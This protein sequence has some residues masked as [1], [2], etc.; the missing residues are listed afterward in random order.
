MDFDEWHH[1]LF[2]AT[3]PAAELAPDLWASYRMDGTIMLQWGDQ[4]KVVGLSD[5]YF[6]LKKRSSCPLEDLKHW[7]DINFPVQCDLEKRNSYLCYNPDVRSYNAYVMR[8]ESVIQ[9]VYNVD[10]KKWVTSKKLEDFESVIEDS[11]KGTLIELSPLTQIP[12][13]TTV[14]Y[15]YVMQDI[16]ERHLD[17]S[18]DYHLAVPTD[19]EGSMFIGHQN[20]IRRLLVDYGDS[21]FNTTSL[22]KALKE[23]YGRTK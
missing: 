14:V 23:H 5:V 12:A 21:H 10:P 20:S 17:Y 15:P 4:H 19:G 22:R 6:S 2:E 1:A 7:V 16:I 9:A 18:N 3:Y 11:L 8:S 13:S